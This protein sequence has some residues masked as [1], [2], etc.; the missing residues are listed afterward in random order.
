MNSF[1]FGGSNAHVIL[2]TYDNNKLISVSSALP[3]TLFTPF[4]FS[5]TSERSLKAQLSAYLKFLDDNDKVNVRDLAYTLGQRRSTFPYRASFAAQ[6]L[7]DLKIKIN[8]KLKENAAIGIRALPLPKTKQAKI[9][10]I[11]TGQSISLPSHMHC[12]S[13]DL[14]Y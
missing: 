10:G 4:M 11:F 9:L 12:K 13:S 3:E 8:A 1:G 7:G 14:G 6:S 5:A 2:E